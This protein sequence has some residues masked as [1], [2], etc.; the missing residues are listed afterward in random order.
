M[1]SKKEWKPEVKYEVKDKQGNISISQHLSK[2]D[3]DNTRNE[4][5]INLNDKIPMY[6]KL[7]LGAG[8]FKANL[9]NVNLKELYVHMGVGRVNLDISGAYKNNIKVNIQGGVGE[10]TVYLPKSIG[11]RIKV[12]KGVGAVNVNGFIQEEGDIYKNSQY[13]KTK[14][15]IE[16]NIETGVGSIKVKQK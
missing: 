12:Q 15:N 1:Y 14:N 11:S 5:N 10:A 2:S 13:G 4:W 6:I 7:G 3:K 8:D 16:V 9:S